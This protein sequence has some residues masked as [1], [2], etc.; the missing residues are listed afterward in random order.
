MLCITCY[1]FVVVPSVPDGKPG[2]PLAERERYTGTVLHK[3]VQIVQNGEGDVLMLG[4]L[5]D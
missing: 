1:G 3:G 4:I 2:I 5:L